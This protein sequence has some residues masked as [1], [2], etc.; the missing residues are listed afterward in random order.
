[1][2][3]GGY[4]PTLHRL[5]RI[6]VLCNNAQASTTK[7]RNG[8]PRIQGDGTEVAIYKFCDGHVKKMNASAT[9]SS[10]RLAHPKLHEIPFDSANKWQISVHSKSRAIFPCGP[11]DE[12]AGWNKRAVAVLKGAPERV[13]NMCTHY[14]HEGE[15]CE[16]TE[17]ARKAILEGGL[18]LGRQGE[19][20]L[21]FADMDLAPDE[22]NIEVEE[23]NLSC[24]L[25][26]EDKQRPIDI[27]GVW[28]KH[29]GEF[30]ELKLSEESPKGGLKKVEEH[31]FEEVY[32]LA[33]D[34]IGVRAG[35]LRLNHG[36]SA[37]QLDYNVSLKDLGYGKGT[38][39]HASIGPYLFRGI[40]RE[41]VNYPFGRAGRDDR[42]PC[43]VG[44]FSMIDPVRAGV[45]EAVEKCQDAG[46]KVI[47]VTGDHP[48][49]AHA[50]AKAVNI[51]GKTVAGKY[52]MTKKEVADKHFG[53]DE[54]SVPRNHSDYQ[55]ALIPGW[56]LSE[57]EKKA[58]QD[59][60]IL[61]NFWDEVL[62]KKSIVF[63]R[64]S[65]QQKLIIVQACQERGGVVAV[66]GDG[67]NDSPALKKADIGVAMGITGTDVA[68]ESADM[69]LKDD[70]FASIV[71][72]V[73]EGRII[74]DNL[75]KSIA[76]TLSSNIPEIAPFLFYQV[77]GIPLPLPTVMIL[78]VDLG[79]D[80]APAISMAH[81]GAESD[82]M[83]KSPREQNR[84]KLVTWNLVSFSYLQIGVLQALAGFYAYFVVLWNYGIAPADTIGMDDDNLFAFVP[85]KYD[86][87]RDGYWMYCLQAE[88]LTS[89]SKNGHDCFYVADPSSFSCYWDDDTF[90]DDG[91]LGTAGA[92]VEPVSFASDEEKKR[93]YSSDFTK[94]LGMDTTF[95]KSTR[96]I[97]ERA[98][99]L[100]A[101]Q[102]Q[103]S[104]GADKESVEHEASDWQH[105]AVECLAHDATSC[106]G[107]QYVAASKTCFWFTS[108]DGGD[109]D[110]NLE[111]NVFRVTGKIGRMG[112]YAD[113]LKKWINEDE[114]SSERELF[115][116]YT[117][118]LYSLINKKGYLKQA[119]VYSQRTCYGLS[120]QIGAVYTRAYSKVPGIN[121]DEFE[122][123]QSWM[124]WKP[125]NRECSTLNNCFNVNANDQR[126][127]TDKGVIAGGVTGQTAEGENSL[128]P[129]SQYTRREALAQANTAYFISII[130]VQWADL[131][132]CKT[133][134]R[135]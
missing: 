41:T 24:H 112:S 79:T 66:T 22:Y 63:A 114:S 117:D 121:C 61:K 127:V 15:E 4:L 109:D 119:K 133:R 76:Y 48:V 52:H 35:T 21:A 44:L 89:A 134:T 108:C 7:D 56:K 27:E 10:Y 102:P 115:G 58:E 132:I 103:E 70:N 43:F 130:I 36:D 120:E 38:V 83:L 100:E 37:E 107:F 59:A 128:Y 118:A 106:A 125:E 8:N 25:A 135:P 93:R 87:Q 85:G 16:M 77:A 30:V 2:A 65:P 31:T 60:S 90:N 122:T 50:I 98:I 42:G 51:I 67:V 99:I 78:L 39:F 88:L 97:L 13:L 12:E 26:Q 18:A 75:K 101:A 40:S 14:L 113:Q 45:P 47:M 23:P 129:I 96:S 72:G 19:R 94:Y 17:D 111:G 1:M 82:I 95:H 6:G 131:M 55:A 54:D 11:H 68:K 104:C 81:E 74:F 80:L 28:I 3:E 105:C 84:D 126:S 34:V 110:L 29:E 57:Y 123:T 32:R 5:I 33:A 64:A 73:E 91:G 124:Y 62:T 116:I 86:Q 9:T 49:T 92:C 20:V 69:I 53:G 71:N 46:I